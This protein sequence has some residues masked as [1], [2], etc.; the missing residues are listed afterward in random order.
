MASEEPRDV[1]VYFVK[2]YTECHMVLLALDKRIRSF[3]ALDFIFAT[4]I[5]FG[6]SA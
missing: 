5:N 4:M 3:A 1:N 2:G 6:I